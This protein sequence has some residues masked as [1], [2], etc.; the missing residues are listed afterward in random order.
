MKLRRFERWLPKRFRHGAGQHSYGIPFGG[1]V[2][3][4]IH[5]LQ[6]ISEPTQERRLAKSSPAVQ[7]VQRRTLLLKGP[8]ERFQL[9]VSV[10]KLIHI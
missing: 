4:V 2:R 9:V 10:D 6:A 5:P 3:H 8:P 1:P 7:H